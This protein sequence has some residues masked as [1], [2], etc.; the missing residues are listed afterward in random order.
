MNDGSTVG[1]I[2]TTAIGSDAHDGL[3]P[4]T[5]KRT[6]TNL[7][8]SVSLAAGDVI[9]IDTGVYSNYTTTI[10]GSG[11]L[12][13]P[14]IVLG[15]TNLV[16]GGTRLIRNSPGADVIAFNGNHLSFRHLVLE[17]GRRGF[18]LI[19]GGTGLELDHVTVRG[20]SVALRRGQWTVRNSLFANNVTLTDPNL[21]SYTFDRCILW[22]NGVDS[23][24]AG[25]SMSLSNSVVVGGDIISPITGDFNVFWRT[26]LL[27]NNR[28]YLYEY[29]MPNSTVAEPGF[30]NPSASNF[31]PVS[32]SGRYNPATGAIVTDAV[33][34]VLIDFGDPGSTLWTN[35]PGPN[36]GR[37][38]VGV[39]GGTSL[40]SRSRTNAWLFALTL[41]DGGAIT[42]TTQ[43]LVWNHGNFPPASTVRLE[44]SPGA[45]GTVWSNI[46]SGI[47]VTNRTHVWN[48]SGLPA[49]KAAWRVVA[50]SDTNVWSRN[51]QPF[52]IGGARVC[53]YINDLSTVGDVYTTS[54]GSDA[55]DGLSPAT[56][57]L[58]VTNLL[59]NYTLGKH[60][61]VFID[62]GIYSN[63]TV[64]VRGYGIAGLPLI[65]QG[66]PKPGATVFRRNASGSVFEF[67]GDHYVL[68]NLTLARSLANGAVNGGNVRLE[69]SVV[70]NNNIAFRRVNLEAVNSIITSNS[71]VINS[72]S[73]TSEFHFDRSVFWN[74]AQFQVSARPWSISNSVVVGGLLDSFA[75]NSGGDFN[76]F[77]N[78]NLEGFPSLSELQRISGRWTY[79][80]VLDP[81][82][83]HSTTGFFFPRSVAG[84][85]NPDTELFEQDAVHS[86]AIDFGNPLSTVWTNEPPPNGNRLNAGAY[87]GTAWASKSRINAWLQALSLND[88]GFLNVPGETVYWTSGNLPSGATVRIEFSFNS[89][90][91][92][93]TFE[94]NV[95]ASAGSFTVTTTN[96]PS[97]LFARWRV[98]LESEPSVNSANMANF[99]YRSGPFTYFVNDASS[100]GD[101]YTSAMGN[102]ANL[103]T[104]PDAPKATLSG[105]LTNYAL[106]PGDVVYVDT[107]VY[108]L[109][110]TIPV[111]ALA[112][113]TNG[114]PVIIQGSTNLLAGGSIIRGPTLGGANAPGF[115]FAS[116]VRDV[117]I[118]NMTIQRKTIGVS[119]N[120]NA[121]IGLVGLRVES[122]F[123]HG[124]VSVNT[125]NLI[126]R[127][128]AI[129]ENF[130][131]GMSLSG[132]GD[133]SVLQS[134]L[135]MNLTN[136]IRTT[137]PLVLVT[138]S[139][140]GAR[141]TWQHI[142]N[143][144]TW[145]NI[146]ANYNALWV[147]Q[148][149]SVARVGQMDRM[150]NSLAAWQGY[151]GMDH[152]SLDADPLF[153]NPAVGDFHLR[154]QTVQGRFDPLLG[155]VTD[156]RT[157][158]LIDAGDP[159]FPFDREPGLNGG[160]ANIGLYGNT[161]EASFVDFPRLF[162][163][164]LNLGG[165]VKGTSTLNWVSSGL[166]TQTVVSLDYSADG[167]ES[168]ST[169]ATGLLA[170]A[171]SF[172]WNTTPESPAVAG[173][174]RVRA[175]DFPSLGSS[176]TNFFGLR[177][178]GLIWFVN[179]ASTQGDVFTA[180][181][182]S[183]TNWVATS[184]RPLDSL[185]RVLERYD[186][187][188]GDRIFVD[189]GDYPI[190]APLTFASRQSGA[191]TS[192]VITVI[193]ATA[194]PNGSTPVSALVGTGS[195][196]QIGI[197][198]DQ[199]QFITFSNLVARNFGTALSA[200][201]AGSLTFDGVRV[202]G[203][204][205]NSIVM[206]LTSNVV[207]HRLLVAQS[208]ATG[209]R[210][211]TNLNLR[212]T[213]SMFISNKLGS[214]ALVGGVANVTNSV[215]VV[216]EPGAAAFTITGNGVVRS[217]YNNF[218]IGPL[219]NV[220]R[221]GGRLYKF[222]V[223]WQQ[224]TTN[225]MN[226]LSH[227]AGFFNVS[228]GDYH[229][230]S[231]VGRWDD[232]ICGWVTDAVH[233]VM[234]D[235]GD[236]GFGIGGEPAPNGSRVNIGLYGGTTQASLS[237]TNARLLTLTLNTGGSIRGTNVLVWS[238]NSA[239]SSHLVYVDVS[240]DNG[241]T[242]T[243]IGTNLLA[244]TGSVIWDTSDV[245]STPLGR[246]RVTSQADPTLTTM[247]EQPFTLNNGPIGY[248]V[249]DGDTDGD[250]Y[251]T[252][253]GDSENDGLSPETPVDSLNAIFARY[254]PAPGDVIY[255]DTGIYPFSSTVLLDANNSGQATNPVV[256]QGSTNLLD[257][258]TRF[259]MNR[260][261]PLLELTQ[262]EG[263]AVQDLILT[264]MRFGVV[265]QTSSNLLFSRIIM[266][267]ATNVSDGSPQSSVGIRL[268]AS[269]GVT[270]DRV[271]VANITNRSG[272]AGIYIQGQGTLVPGSATIR[273]SVL[274]DNAHGLW[275]LEDAPISLSNSV[276]YAQGVNA[277]G[278][279]LRST[280]GVG[281]DYNVY[282][283]ESSARLAELNRVISA[284][285]PLIRMPFSITTLLAWQEATGLDANT[286]TYDPG[287]ANPGQLDFGLLS[288]AGRWTPDGVV[289]DLVSS[290]MID[291]GN[292]GWAFSGEPTPNG[293]RVNI[294]PDG[295]SDRASLTPTNRS[296]ILR[297][298]YDGGVARGA[299]VPLR[300]DLR[301]DFS[302]N[303]VRIDLS[304][305]FGQSWVNVAT[306]VPASQLTFTWNTTASPSGFGRHWRLINEQQ[307]LMV[308]TSER[309]FS[310]RN[311]NTVFY[312]NDQSITGTVYTTGLGSS[313]NS[314]LSASQPMASIAEVL[315]A[316]TL[317][318][319]DTIYV[320]T[321]IYP[322]SGGIVVEPRDSYMAPGVLSIVGSTN[323][324]A[325]G[326]ILTNGGFVVR[327]A[328][329]TRIRNFTMQGFVP[330]AISV[331]LSTNIH[332]EWIETAGA[333]VGLFVRSGVDVGFRHTFITG[334][335]TNGILLDARNVNVTFTHGVIWTN[336]GV[337]VTP[338]QEISISNSVLGV[339]GAGN[340]IYTGA[341]NQVLNLNDNVYFMTN[342]GRL[343]RLS[344]GPGQFPREIANLAAWRSFLIAD[345]RSMARDPL[346][347]DAA[348]RNFHPLS[349]GG[350]WSPGVTN[351]VIDAITSPLVDSGN[352]VHPFGSETE[353]NGGRVNI[354]LFGN[355]ARASKSPAQPDILLVTLDD[356]GSVSGTNVL[357]SWVTRGSATSHLVRVETSLDG[358]ESWTVLSSNVPPTTTEV[359]WNTTGLMSTVVGQWRVVSETDNAISVASRNFFA[360]RNGPVILY[361]N[362]V[363]TDGDVYTTSPGSFSA[364]GITPSSPL[365]SLKTLLDR[366][367][368]EP[369]D[370]VYIDTGVY[371][372]TSTLVIDQLDAGFRAIGSTNFAAGGSLMV[373]TNVS[374][375]IRM[376][377]AP[378]T[379]IDYLRVGAVNT[380]FDIDE[381]AG[382][383]IHQVDVSGAG[384]GFRIE[385][386]NGVILQN[387]SIRNGST[388]IFVLDSSG[389]QL[390][391]LVIWSNAIS[392]VRLSKASVRVEN[393][394]IGV[395]SGPESLGFD[396][397]A[398]S[399]IE[400][401]FNFFRMV[402]EGIVA[403][404]AVPGSVLD[405]RW[406]TVASWSRETGNDVFSL[407]G[408][409]GFHDPDNGDFHP[410]SQAGRFN[411]H[412]GAFVSDTTTSVLIDAG[413]PISGFGLETA[414]HGGRA[415]IGMFGNTSL[416]SRSPTNG[417]LTVV[418]LNDGGRAEGALVPL[419]WVA[420]G[421]STG[422]TVR[423]ETSAD[424]GVS[425]STV[426]SNVA[427]TAGALFW[428]SQTNAGWFGR[429]RVISEQNP[430]IQS[431][432]TLPF[433]VRNVGLSLYMNDLSTNGNIY[434]TGLGS[435]ANTGTTPSS[436]RLSLQSLLDDYDLEPGD[437]IYIDT[438]E[439]VINSPIRIG[440]FD[441]W[442]NMANKTPLIQGGTS[443]RIQGSTNDAALGTRFLRTGSGNAIELKDALGFHVSHLDLFLVQAGS[444]TGISIQDSPY[445][446]I[447]WTRIHR[448]SLGVDVGGSDLTRI[449]HTLVRGS[450]QRGIRVRGSASVRLDH[451]V[452]WSNVVGLV[453][454]NQG[455]VIA[456][457]NA[458]V[459]LAPDSAGWMR[460]DSSLPAAKGFLD[461]DYNVLWA[462]NQAFIGQLAGSQ[463][464]AGLRRIRR[465]DIW[466][467]ESGLD[468]HSIKSAP[469]FVNPNGGD[470]RP[471][472]PYGR[473]VPG[474]GYVSNPG[475]AFSPLIDTG[476]PTAPFFRE[477]SPNGFRANIG[478]YG[479]SGQASLSPTNGSLQV[480]TF[481]DGGSSAGVIPLRWAVAGPAASHPVQLD[482][483]SDGGATWTN[484][485]SNLLAS[486]QFY[487]WD[488]VPYGAAAAGRWRIFSEADPTV[489][490]TNEAFFALR[491]EGTIPYYINNAS[492]EGNV[493]TT[494]PGNDANDGFLPSTPKATLQNLLNTIDLEPGDVVYMDTGTYAVN[495]DI[496]WGELDRGTTNAPIILR[497]S[498]NRLAGGTV[499]DRVTGLDSALV[500]SQ[501]EGIT[502]ENITFTRAARG[503]LLDLSQNITLRGVTFTENTQAGLQNNGTTEVLLENSRVWNNPTNGVIVN[504]FSRQIGGQSVSSIGTMTLRNNTFWGNQFGVRLGNGGSVMA[505]NNLF[506]V[507]GPESRVF[508]ISPGLTN[509]FGN[510][511]AFFRQSGALV[512]ER[513]VNFGG[514]EFYPRLIDWQQF[515]GNDRF[516]LSH[517]PLVANPV[518]GDFHLL[519]AGGRVLPS[520]AVTND[521]V[522]T[523]SP[524]IDAGNPGS[525]WTNEPSPN[526]GRVNI[527]RYGNTW[528]ASRSRTNG[529]LLALTMNDGG[530]Y[531]SN[532]VLRW[533]A[534]NWLTSST[535]RIEYANN[536]V[537][538]GVLASNVPVYQAE[539]PWDASG[540]PVTQLARWRVV[541]EEEP[542]RLSV[543]QSPFVIKPEPIVVY[544]NNNSTNGN[545]YTFAVGSS[546]N[547]GLTPFDPLNDPGVALERFPFSEGDVL[548]IDTGTYMTTNP[549]CLRIG[550][551]G[552]NLKA[553][554]PGD[555]F[556]IVGSTNA[557]AGGTVI[558]SSTCNEHGLLVVNT[559]HIG[560]E[561]LRFSGFTNGLTVIGSRDVSLRSIR[562]TQNE[563][564][565]FIENVIDARIEHSAAWNNISSGLRV[566]GPDSTVIWNHGVLWSNQ[567][568][569]I[570]HL[571]GSLAI[572]N[573]I[574]GAASLTG[575]LYQ[576][577]SQL[578]ITRGD[579]NLYA[580]NGNPTLVRDLFGGVTY[581]NLRQWQVA[582]GM[583]TNSFI[584]SPLM[585]SP[586]Q[587]NFHLRSDA[588]RFDPS[589]GIYVQDAVTSWAIDAGAMNH[590][591]AS[592]PMP[593]GGRVNIGKHG[594][595]GKASLSSSLPGLFVISL[596]DGGTAA[597]P[598][599]LIWL[600]RGMSP[601]N[602]VRLEY[603]PNNGIDWDII[604]S[605]VPASAQSYLWINGEL[606]STPLGRWR[607]I[608]ESD[609]LIQDTTPSLFTIRNGP[610][611]YYVNDTNQ[612]GDVYTMAPGSPANNGITVSTP[613][614][615][616]S[617][618]IDR[619]QLEGG[620]I[621]FIDT[622]VYTLTNNIVIRADDSG[623]ATNRVQ[624]WGSTNRAAGGT[625]FVRESDRPWSMEGENNDAVFEII[626]ARFLEMRD[627]TL[628]NANSGILIANPQAQMDGLLFRDV[629][630]R[631]G[632][633]FGIRTSST[634]SNHFQRVLI[635]NMKGFGFSGAASSS[636]I[637]SSVIWS[638]DLGAVTV[639]GGSIAITNS[640][641]H[642][643]G[644]ITNPVITLNN[645]TIRSDYNNFFRLGES[646]YGLIEGEPFMGLPQWSQRTTQDYHSVSIDPLFADPANGD[647]HPR[648]PAG[649]F[650]PL[651]ETFLTD[652]ADFSWLIDTGDPGTGFANEPSP[653]GGRRNIGLHGNTG[654][655][656]KSRGD[657]WLLPI[658]AMAGGR[659]GGIFPLHWTY[660]NLDS[661]NRVILDFSPD[662][663]TNWYTIVENVPINQD[664]YFWNSLNA[665]PVNQSPIT[666]WRVTVAGATNLTA[667]IETTFGLNGP[668]RFFLNPTNS[669]GD[670]FTS[671]P[672]N[673][674]NLG[675]FSN[676]PKATL[677]SLFDSWDLEPLDTIYVDTGS[678]LFQS[679]D[680]AVMRRNNRGVAG[681]PITLLGSENGAIF[682]GTPVIAGGSPIFI[683]SIEAPHILVDG[684]RMRWG[685]IEALGTNVV[686]RNMNFDQGQARLLGPFGLIESFTMSNGFVQAIGLQSTIRSGNI[687]N[688]S[689]QLLGSETRLENSVVSGN[690]TPLVQVGGT[691]IVIVNNTL[692]ASRT[693]VQQIG[694]DSRATLRNNILVANGAAG[695]ALAV[696]R[697]GG[698]IESD[699]NLYVLR[700][701][702][703]F[704][705]ANEGLWERL[706]YWQQ[707]SGLDANSMVAD[708]LFANEA[709]RDFRLR[710]V[711]GRFDN[712]VW[713]VDGVHSP[714][715]DAGAPFDNFGGEPAPN[716]GRIN[717][718]AFGNTE[719]ASKSRT[720]PWVYAIT[721]NDG[722]VIRNTETLRWLAG[723]MDPTNRV[724]LQYSW[725]A[726]ATWETIITGLPALSGSFG[727][728]TSTASN[729]LD[730]LWR[731][732]LEADPG[733]VDQTDSIFNIRN[734]IRS[735]FVN[736]ATT[737]GNVFT[738]APGNN[739]NDGRT[740][741]T[742]KATLENL[743]ATYDTEP[744]DTIYVDTGIYTSSVIQVIWSRGGDSNANMT[745][746]GST[747]VAA[748]GTVIRR[749]TQTGD[750]LVVNAS[751]VTVR[752]I[753]FENAERGL[754]LASNRWNLVEQVGVRSNRT[755]IAVVGGGDH[756][757]R[758]SR[759]LNNTTGGVSVVNSENVSVENVTFVNNQP[760][761][762]LFT[763]VPNSVIQNNIFFLDQATSNQQFAIAGPT[764]TV[765]TTFIDYNVY[766]FGPASVTN[767]FI[768]GSFNQLLPWQRLQGKDFRSAIT[769]PAFANLATG[770][771]HLRSQAGRYFPPFQ[772]FV[773]DGETSWAIDKGNPNSDFSRETME[774][775]GRINIGAY[776]NT[777]YASRGVT[778]E[779]VFA[780][781]GN[782]FLPIT[783]A[784]NPYPLIW[785][786]LNVPDEATVSVQYSGDGG[787][788]WITLQ[789][790][791]PIYQEYIIWTNSP[792]FNSFD[793]RWRIIG[794]GPAYTNYFDV[795]DGKI[796]TFFG[797]HRISNIGRTTNN[798]NQFV[799]RGAW[800]EE[801]QIQF[802]TNRFPAATL[803]NWQNAGA[804]TTLV[805]G[806]DTPF[807]DPGSSNDPFRV[808]RV[809]WLGT[810][811]VGRN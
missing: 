647:F 51:R 608:L 556:R 541:S 733:V 767:A 397:D 614:H 233:S 456:R 417:T 86:P 580:T 130:H 70:Q 215:F 38:N 481:R 657:P 394:V 341:S 180:A 777:V 751:Y 703:W 31:F 532:G 731:V 694:A 248:F 561:H 480:I 255:I 531:P 2:Y 170:S 485:V 716:G 148:D 762:V 145:T 330:A 237:L 684:I 451:S 606:D 583:D 681:S 236:P 670:V 361:I 600:A 119:L 548:Y 530:R 673:D 796:T 742:P 624:F 289:T 275:A 140:L 524:L 500:I 342:G 115:T 222:P 105:I 476:D 392:G 706:L 165:Y 698:V 139:V 303:T 537:D 83:L 536:G 25:S 436:P 660:G 592:E 459:S 805:V 795:N 645:A 176:T 626:R 260:G 612:V 621:V 411:R 408:D 574:I 97:S 162:T 85:Y 454:E 6:L 399:A 326:T 721:M 325:G 431:S 508:L 356:G 683:V 284:A 201:R 216:D 610:I 32:V 283:I 790:G 184:N 93:N 229:L 39:H 385:D 33:H 202:I 282:R 22:E 811:G 293:G 367:E 21:S 667:Q 122:N 224:A 370:I 223:N 618:I 713:V 470:F 205:T 650:D 167:G 98:V 24:G 587:G 543:V 118:R 502:I 116:G 199:A 253:P 208:A 268:A 472:S 189:R 327:H 160:R 688:G 241:I 84:R 522:G 300:W 110:G 704:G 89:G 471:Q 571:N 802:A 131:G 99:T 147:E 355:T 473:F 227:D 487:L 82:I 640:V 786:V 803:H 103:G 192:G 534:G 278:L 254:L 26:R 127:N 622:G 335:Q 286:L 76:I 423:I 725:N 315:A 65:F 123:Q 691:N 672:G 582:S 67:Q 396:L 261:G 207:F 340:F 447:E 557:A 665:T 669:A 649:R 296:I 653:N 782:D 95:L 453:A 332:A 111:T 328:E 807:I 486:T 371:T 362:D 415:N 642:A 404:R 211:V 412:T 680:L 18:D 234:I 552:D 174:W 17:S 104:T 641:L 114:N 514:N 413:D 126:L 213:H 440:R 312:V 29:A 346:F 581:R 390:R 627:M 45:G 800:D 422:H 708:P 463:Y 244:S 591:F 690:V 41:N 55:Q 797:V 533:A 631:N 292:P 142:Y 295:N 109:S 258:G 143:A 217:D 96:F 338:V 107:G 34:S 197:F 741:A 377:Q 801:Y 298:F 235:S 128:T 410:R 280:V 589:L 728:D 507:N 324:S 44:Y 63:Y 66:S 329:N 520:G 505:E 577:N 630:I 54:P 702:A 512:A 483:S 655:A 444:G 662:S 617:T 288:Q 584:G 269:S 306:G 729:S 632:G 3:T 257:G 164:N 212:F 596:R 163:G 135:W 137:G 308:A 378:A 141:G 791:V 302:G 554:R 220:A 418:R 768:Y 384:T 359:S 710:S 200:N 760:F 281:A 331:A 628:E 287:F 620:D 348:N 134:V 458:V 383:V 663:G 467:S 793:A 775:G 309:P 267:G 682:D 178:Q 74:N 466:N 214:V 87:G 479:H 161:P 595:T 232:T 715:I 445:S 757:I 776:G 179:D 262:V 469:L 433:A 678:Y 555:P 77:W 517:D 637:D 358:G 416:A 709:G 373:F 305:D 523:Y 120:S 1:D 37:I 542:D 343:A 602:R 488:S 808:Y 204:A 149:A 354:G 169:L 91:S 240:L 712:G 368:L 129:R 521:L 679:N 279:R 53:F 250:V 654:E 225:D 769:N 494:A 187:E 689:L 316:Y 525:L 740:P 529:W 732:V 568:A 753:T 144:P 247:T 351:F 219:A 565:L 652:D 9:Y 685:S 465:M 758:S 545:V 263:L 11:T 294:G 246:W 36:G 94:T 256:I 336:Q 538:F 301:G 238:A 398:D 809:L 504:Q 477:P 794:E 168:W 695:T 42:G 666:K 598:Q 659:A 146:L 252:A 43:T 597:S 765:L 429:W 613:V 806:G 323:H 319:G 420:R 605:N 643:Y 175:P 567:L 177:N 345:S 441:A 92:W 778:N 799:W 560:V 460:N 718:G 363:S 540:E 734:D 668:F 186:L 586:G 784:D 64:L 697:T 52:S 304:Q 496:V 230:Q 449:R 376:I 693:P 364:T 389:L 437:T 611:F 707:N 772:A 783:E 569:G 475:E 391:H 761:S 546:T 648:S 88:G 490:S 785:H 23:S 16:G 711:E 752:D 297:S 344:L 276:I 518:G 46:A 462:E 425:W 528:E 564:G 590:A 291:A 153:V 421:A 299:S 700:N 430:S 271:V 495:L 749:P 442:N 352:P 570:H 489:A 434:T 406:Q 414:P 228:L 124:V 506:Q 155:W 50:E 651:S 71:V 789:S 374:V 375:G 79:S 405:L 723:G 724:T 550:L 432:N 478:I 579:F 438:G 644:T 686:F 387:T 277:F 464:P 499:I 566:Q 182:G 736:N 386:S 493:F 755:G 349:S 692:V 513:Q 266:A 106:G 400:S 615:S 744:Y 501:T 424:N 57:K 347:A 313:T 221:S 544:V 59:A 730:A 629:V 311:S 745:I 743:L 334:A 353:P 102:D 619:Y 251:T 369:G 117:E 498:T 756:V 491:Q 402:N 457:N 722:G 509:I 576:V 407:T 314:G 779:I 62:T 365:D 4:A 20:M 132:A 664:G 90:F 403:R 426:Q 435:Q 152:R 535:V 270:V 19:G 166:P 804:V 321:G 154:S 138:N 191:P 112:A 101:I 450:S 526:G 601:T 439:Y 810:N 604:V 720:T 100:A 196:S 285:N 527:G 58:T 455:A 307:P 573:S 735:F 381:S 798:L 15:S 515:F 603:T 226:S 333:G 78:V 781:T 551:I 448:A 593:N 746:R 594:N 588:G 183:A 771:F 461:A 203:T 656:S 633:Y 646:A 578:A 562:S 218:L 80:T 671:G 382:I 547:S 150:M 243:N 393:S 157:S 558:L 401:D 72:D 121:R 35:E 380:A 759:I 792:T 48:V 320:D 231:A 172:A 259:N 468:I 7:F 339:S 310:V 727:W 245:P 290:V 788:S 787:A 372:N 675:I 151:S 357:L 616:V 661:T 8:A 49:M 575:L 73:V 125:T 265:A 113:G 56:P 510:Y 210:G 274:W 206:N 638:N 75:F 748:G 511:N 492:T 193:G 185:T 209:L 677:K 639:A 738:T 585:A 264:N 388:G 428:D 559:S 13:N 379:R 754:L 68:R 322:A 27:N 549:F 239:A 272:S 474:V 635:H 249:N 676:A 719:Q 674:E 625:R 317:I 409:P 553:G 273:N 10:T 774:N 658:T 395:L 452:L 482:Y 136:A 419:T 572:S 318:G 497:G 699:Y 61:V 766:F 133:A 443:V 763:N 701:G 60:D 350:R 242:W 81:L 705:R 636:F 770:D 634:L 609:E 337:N 739:A 607:I 446:L 750:V 360:V 737:N 563:N 14:I 156:T 173:L 623:S 108:S 503:V 599:P 47:P 28:A 40:A 195:A 519:S 5:P 696:D 714:A 194:C 188:P 181:S 764:G 366:Y 69:N 773:L 171:E 717:V 158:P 726:G 539:F 687:L 30:A 427:A 198:A 780:R 516:S 12:G 159:A 747:N 484:I 190:V